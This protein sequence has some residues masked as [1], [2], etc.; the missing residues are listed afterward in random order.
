MKKLLFALVFALSPSLFFAQSAFDKFDGMDN[1]TS[2]IVNR[3]MF[4]M[5]GNVKNQDSQQYLD[6]IKKLT[7]L[8]VF[9]TTS[10]AI[11]SDMKSTSEKYIKAAGLEELMRVNDQGK[12]VR[13]MVKSGS[14]P[15]KV[16]ELLMLME[17][18]GKN[19]TVL[20]S[21]T[22]DFDL[23]DLSLLTEKLKVPGGDVLKRAGR[24]K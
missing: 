7:N 6:L 22:G 9:T 12:N 1:V 2:V 11:S 14:G 13:I 17:G 23:N 19:E 15:T 3:K 8:R 10:T 16:R 24:T 20:M 4:E 21:L 18:S 5:M